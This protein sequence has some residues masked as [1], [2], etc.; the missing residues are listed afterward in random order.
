MNC[1][2]LNTTFKI[3]TPVISYLEFTT[4]ASMRKKIKL[5]NAT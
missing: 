5:K 1:L 3:K 2:S 4:V